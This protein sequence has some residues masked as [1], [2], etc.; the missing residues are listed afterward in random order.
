MTG[1]LTKIPPKHKSKY[2][3]Q[4]PHPLYQREIKIVNNNIALVILYVTKNP[5]D[6]SCNFDL[7]F[8]NLSD[9]LYSSK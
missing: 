9:I 7:Y 3:E 2:A 6:N 1:C 8:T 5:I 4:F